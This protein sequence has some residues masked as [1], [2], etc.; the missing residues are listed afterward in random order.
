MDTPVCK[1]FTQLPFSLEIPLRGISECL[2]ALVSVQVS[3]L[4]G[5][6]LLRAF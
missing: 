1:Y 6:S 4:L 2:A 5:T 3:L